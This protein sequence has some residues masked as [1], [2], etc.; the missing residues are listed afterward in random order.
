[1]GF[2]VNKQG[3]AY[4]DP[5]RR[6]TVGQQLYDVH[7]GLPNQW[8][9]GDNMT[10]LGGVQQLPPNP[11][12]AYTPQP[13]GEVSDGSGRTWWAPATT[14]DPR[15]A[16][17]SDYFAGWQPSGQPSGQP[18]GQP[19][20]QPGGQNAGQNVSDLFRSDAM[21]NFAQA[22][23]NT[24][25][26]GGRPPTFQDMVSQ[27][28]TAMRNAPGGQQPGIM[29]VT[30]PQLGVPQIRQAAN[31]VAG[32]VSAPPTIRAPQAQA[33]LADLGDAGAM[34]KALFESTYRPI[35]RQLE[36]QLQT[37]NKAASASL[38]NRG[39]AGSGVEQ[40]VL[41]D[42]RDENSRQRA[43]AMYDASNQATV[44]RFGYE[45]QAKL[46]N[47][48]QQQA[49]NLANA[50][51]DLQTQIS[52]AQN[53]LQ[54][55]MSSAQLQTQA[56]I[57]NAQNQTQANIAQADLAGRI[58]MANAQ[59][60]LQAQMANNQFALQQQQQQQQTYFGLMGLSYQQGNQMTRDFLDMLKIGMGDV[61]HL[62]TLDQQLLSTI[63]NTYLGE[64]GMIVS[65]GGGAAS[66][67]S[68]SSSGLTLGA[69][70]P[71]K[72]PKPAEK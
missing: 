50:G 1:M 25:G 17:V 10:A 58:G 4:Q 71:S 48:Q 70:A 64:G 23:M 15:G 56:S 29:P 72:V 43:N 53:V 59:N 9:T 49:V 18:G 36:N 42:I 13:A 2:S 14:G 35:E 21:Y 60:S 11:P 32:Q 24:L 61:E 3:T 52:N 22:G 54:A 38:A 8:Q 62:D 57:A 66:T 45:F 16:P 34:Q 7:S 41:G 46:F 31:A 67:G 20:G 33:S 12:S 40:A 44:Q 39:L 30:S 5:V 69:E 55:H 37:Q 28:E 68:A 65:A 26:I 19:S 6:K 63:L 27:Y 47:A 51:Y